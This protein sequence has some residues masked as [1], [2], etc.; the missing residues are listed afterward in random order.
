MEHE[1]GQLKAGML[2]DLVLLSKDIAHLPAEKLAE[3]QATMTVC[4][5]K[6]VYQA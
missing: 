1:K 6:I 3:V 5:G 2:A 4:D